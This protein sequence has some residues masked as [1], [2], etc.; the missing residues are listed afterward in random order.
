MSSV[1]QASPA[2]PAVNTLGAFALTAALEPA[3]H[4]AGE[5]AASTAA[6]AAA[7]AADSS[8]GARVIFVSSGGQVCPLV[9]NGSDGFEDN[10]SRCGQ[11]TGAPAHCFSSSLPAAAC[12][13]R[14]ICCS[15]PSLLRWRTWRQS[16]GRSL[17]ARGSMPATSGGRYVLAR[18]ALVS[19][20][21]HGRRSMTSSDQFSKAGFLALALHALWH[22]PGE[23]CAR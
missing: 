6:G 13:G 21:M 3:L 2:S 15:T 20:C 22:G 5:P 7:G 16:G 19:L 8:G 23:A 14:L 9:C 10:V 4:A 11:L 1:S 12:P 18:Q 17:M